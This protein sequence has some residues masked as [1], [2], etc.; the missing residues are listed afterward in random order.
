MRERERETHFKAISQ[1]PPCALQDK[2][3]SL[4][5]FNLIPIVSIFNGERS[6]GESCVYIRG[7]ESWLAGAITVKIMGVTDE[8]I[9]AL[10]SFLSRS[11]Q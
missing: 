9:S 10:F 7:P 4:G 1:R 2:V 8:T 6:E 11:S 5:P 3:R